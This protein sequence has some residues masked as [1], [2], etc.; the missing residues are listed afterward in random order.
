MNDVLAHQNRMIGAPWLLAAFGNLEASRKV[1]KILEDEFNR[2]AAFIFRNDLLT[3]VLFEDTTN[4]ENHF[5][6]ASLDGI[7]NRVIHD[8]FAIGS[9]TIQLLQSTITAAHAGSKN[10]EC[11]FHCVSFFCYLN[12]QCCL[13]CTAK[14]QKYCVTSPKKCLKNI[15]SLKN[16]EFFAN[17][18]ELIKKIIIFASDYN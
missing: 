3:E 11:W 8:G 16:D 1:V 7:V 13:Y 4:D 6:E 15:K 18:G 10:K 12:K 9:K 14:I 17:F 2:N 5:T